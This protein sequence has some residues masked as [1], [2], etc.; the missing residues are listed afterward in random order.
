MCEQLADAT[1]YLHMQTV[2]IKG[3]VSACQLVSLSVLGVLDIAAY[4]LFIDL[5]ARSVLVHQSGKLKLCLCGTTTHGFPP[6]VCLTPL[7]RG[8]AGSGRRRLHGL[9]SRGEAPEHC[10]SP[11]VGARDSEYGRLHT[12]ERRV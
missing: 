7:V 8:G 10:T 5:G 11:L 6:N 3:A 9:E 1:A 2:L 4:W 12:L